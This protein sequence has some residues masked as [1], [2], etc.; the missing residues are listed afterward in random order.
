MANDYECVSYT[1]ARDVFLQHLQ[2]AGSH[3][4][5]SSSEYSLESAYRAAIHKDDFSD[6]SF[7]LTRGNEATAFVFAHKT[8]EL[9]SYNGSGAEIHFLGNEKNDAVAVVDVLSR[10]AGQEGLEEFS[11]ADTGS[12]GILSAL[13][14]VCFNLG[15]MPH[16]HLRGLID[17]TQEEE[18]IKRNIRKSYKSLVNQGR[19]EM[20]FVYVTKDNPDRKLFESF[21]Q[22]H[23]LTAGR[24]TRPI[25]SW[26][27]QFAMIEAGCSELVLG[28]L[29]EHGLVSSAL[30]M[31]HGDFSSYAVAVYNR[32]LFAEKPLAH[33]NV[34]EGIA[35]AKARG[36]KWFNLG[37][38][39]SKRELS[40]KEFNIVK[41]KKGFCS[42]LACFIEWTMPAHVPEQVIKND[43]I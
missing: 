34:F 18:A 38:L 33:A 4:L 41:F 2:H 26:D 9:C 37:V 12:A 5:P 20:E 23:I 17:L 25:E 7:C 11:V 30:F 39:H 36:K 31:D 32:E 28:Y 13:G 15:G 43:S 29:P 40:E 6:L 14:E 16:A 19:R 21:R 3:G 35:R 10:R 22:F 1:T 42:S 8:G 27:V 24:E